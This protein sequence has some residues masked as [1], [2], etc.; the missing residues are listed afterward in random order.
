[1]AI[2]TEPALRLP[3]LTSA[4]IVAARHR[5]RELSLSAGFAHCTVTLIATALSEIARNMLEHAADGEVSITL[6]DDGAKQGIEIVAIDR[7]PGIAD[8]P[9]LLANELLTGPWRPSGLGLAG[10]RQLMDEFEMVSTPGQG[11][12]VTMKKWKVNA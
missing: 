1:M 8:V 4:D 3:I 5:C 7:G 6:I 2:E 10:A 11:T 9:A 12:T